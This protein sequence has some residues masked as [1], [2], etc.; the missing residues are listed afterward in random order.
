MKMTSGCGQVHQ[1]RSRVKVAHMVVAREAGTLTSMEEASVVEATKAAAV[2]GSTAAEVVKAKG[3]I[4][5]VEEEAAP[6][7]R[8]VVV[9]GVAVVVAAVAVITTNRSMTWV[10]KTTPASPTKMKEIRLTNNQEE[11]THSNH[12]QRQRPCSNKVAAAVVVVEEEDSIIT[13]VVTTTITSTS[14]HISNSNSLVVVEAAVGSNNKGIKINRTKAEGQQVA[15]GEEWD[16]D[17]GVRI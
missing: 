1:V 9:E 3:V 14:H 8:A 4:S 10:R 5:G 17:P 2:V 11:I 13:T 12:L 15:A 6:V 7:R 16:M